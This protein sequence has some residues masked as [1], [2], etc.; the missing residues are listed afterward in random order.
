MVYRATIP[1]GATMP[2]IVDKTEIV[3]IKSI[4][5]YDKNPR[6]GNVDAIAESLETSGQFKPIVVNK[7]TSQILAGNHTFLAARKLGWDT[8]YVSFVDVDDETAKRIVLADN[9][10]ADMGEYDDSVLAE[11]IASLPDISGTGYSEIE[12]DDLIASVETDVSASIDSVNSA[13]DA[14]RKL[15]EDWEHSQTFEGSPLGEEP[16]PDSSATATL[17]AKPSK[18]DLEDAPERLGGIVQL[19]APDEVI[20]EGVGPWGIPALKEDMLMTF[21]DLPDNLDSWGGSATKD[22]PDDDQWWLYN[23]G[24]DS[25]SGM[26]DISKVI[27]SFYAFDSYFDNW[28]DYPDRYVTKILNSGIKYILTPN[29]S[30]PTELPRVE[31]LW[32]LYRSR[33][34]G[35]YCQEAGLKVCPDLEWPHMVDGYLEEHVLGTLPVGVPLIAMQWQSVKNDVEQKDIDRY[36]SDVRLVLNELKPEGVLIYAGAN[37]RKVMQEVFDDYPQV[38]LKMVGTRLEK[39][40]KQVRIKKQTI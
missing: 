5:T 22:W 9:K 16:E 7:R 40:S 8:I 18:G 27:V 32:A 33:W 38:K 6:I 28:W 4:K 10:T 29:W 36:K 14:E 11:L 15:Q 17:P 30:Q 34:V 24:I 2:I 20:F 21:D 35:R 12:V 3:P 19:Q 13:I 31:N 37:G 23:W 1:L 39:L 25:T 26:K